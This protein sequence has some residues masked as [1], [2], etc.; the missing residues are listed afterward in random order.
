MIKAAG[1]TSIGQASAACPPTTY[2][3]DRAMTIGIVEAGA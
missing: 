1:G 3:L 2:P